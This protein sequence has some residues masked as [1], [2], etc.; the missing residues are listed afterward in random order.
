MNS[1]K[2]YDKW[3]ENYQKPK[4]E[5]LNGKEDKTRLKN[6]FKDRVVEG[7]RKKSR[8]GIYDNGIDP[9]D[10]IKDFPHHEIKKRKRGDYIPENKLMNNSYIPDPKR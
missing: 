1:N 4:L 10:P 7:D 9:P 5:K 6:T 3:K 8:H 2:I